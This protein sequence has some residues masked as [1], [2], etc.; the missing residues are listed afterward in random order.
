MVL[1][2]RAEE[3]AT[4]IFTPYHRLPPPARHISCRLAHVLVNLCGQPR[5]YLLSF[6]IRGAFRF[7][8]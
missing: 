7:V 5:I 4:I 1:L 2:G 3:T 6:E 8:P